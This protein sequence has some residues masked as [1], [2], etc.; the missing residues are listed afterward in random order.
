MGRI[1]EHFWLLQ[2]LIRGHDGA[3]VWSTCGQGKA[4]EA[5]TS[6]N[7]LRKALLT[8]TSQR[9]QTQTFQTIAPADCR[10]WTFAMV[11][12]DE[13]KSLV[14]VVEHYFGKVKEWFFARNKEQ[15]EAACTA[16]RVFKILVCSG[17]KQQ[18][19]A[20]LGVVCCPY[21]IILSVK[22]WC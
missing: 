7:Q 5:W 2:L 8:E 19:A 1:P 22:G 3:P 16:Y 18:V 15:Q 13:R 20:V 12:D 14:M 4:A 21:C 6:I 17:C 10:Y 9:F 11:S